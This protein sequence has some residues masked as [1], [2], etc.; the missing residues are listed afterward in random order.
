M[1]G[2]LEDLGRAPQDLFPYAALS[3]EKRT[4]DR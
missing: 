4:S 1:S 2:I 3:A